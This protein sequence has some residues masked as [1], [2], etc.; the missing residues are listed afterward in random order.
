M[1]WQFSYQLNQTF[2]CIGPVEVRFLETALTTCQDELSDCMLQIKGVKG[3]YERELETNAKEVEHE[4]LHLAFISCE[5]LT[6][7]QTHCV[8]SVGGML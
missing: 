1:L 4:D 5:T 6:T 7:F 3:R 2:S 8:I